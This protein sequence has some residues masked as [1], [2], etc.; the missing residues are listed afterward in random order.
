M[1]LPSRTWRDVL[2]PSLPADLFRTLATLHRP[3]TTQELA[4]I[5]GRHHNTVRVQLAR[6]AEAGLVERRRTP[7]P[8]GRPRDMWSISAEARPDDLNPDAGAQL[9]VWLTRA[10]AG[11][12]DLAAVEAT[13]REIGRELADATSADDA[14]ADRFRDAVAALGFAPRRDGEGRLVLRNCP[15]RA[16]VQQNAA[17]ICTLHRGLTAGLIDRLAPGGRLTA[18][19]ARDPI[20]AGCVV[21]VAG[22]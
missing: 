22:V 15:Y 3:A 1:D 5:V 14:P 16:A 7:Q 4:D 13:G 21:E 18:F 19:V 17:V 12:R 11:Q 20:Q 2:G 9:S 8:R 10:L 6:L